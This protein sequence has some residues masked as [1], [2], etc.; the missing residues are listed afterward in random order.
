[1]KGT[2]F[3][4]AE[5]GD[6]NDSEDA[7]ELEEEDAA[8]FCLNRDTFLGTTGAGAEVVSPDS[9]PPPSWR[10]AVAFCPLLPPLPLLMSM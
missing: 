3:P 10:P 2:V 5:G 8:L 6:D 1:M 4:V 9:L 7:E